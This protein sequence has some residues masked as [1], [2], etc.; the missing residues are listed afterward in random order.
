M[1]A[2]TKSNPTDE[3]G[4]HWLVSIRMDMDELRS[5]EDNKQ[6]C[7]MAIVL[8]LEH[9][10]CGGCEKWL[11]LETIDVCTAD[12]KEN[13]ASSSDGTESLS[14]SWYLSTPTLVVRDAPG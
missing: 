12:E 2:K 13:F 7:H 3:A 8:L 5:K 9:I 14:G 10:R 11:D 6:P 1:Y 4:Y